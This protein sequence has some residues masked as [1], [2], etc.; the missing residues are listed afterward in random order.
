MG[1]ELAEVCRQPV[2]LNAVVG[3]HSYGL[4]RSRGRDPARPEKSL[5]QIERG[6]GIR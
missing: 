4:V 3:N 1:K 2:R 5:L 6:S